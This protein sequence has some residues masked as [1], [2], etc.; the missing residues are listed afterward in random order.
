MRKSNI[1]LDM[2]ASVGIRNIVYA[3]PV[4]LRCFDQALDL[5]WIKVL[6]YATHGGVGPAAADCYQ[7]TV[8]PVEP[9]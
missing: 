6:T 8:T 4:L 7:N 1:H 5:V 2:I 3:V 9:P